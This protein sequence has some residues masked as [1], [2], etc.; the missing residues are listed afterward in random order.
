METQ[1]S[2]LIKQIQL[3]TK[4]QTIGGIPRSIS[5]QIV[6]VVE[7]NP[8]LTKASFAVNGGKTSSGPTTIITTPTNQ[9]FYLTSVIFS[10]TKDAAC[11]VAS[12]GINLSCVINGATVNFC[13]IAGLTLTAQSATVSANYGMH[14]IKIDRGTNILIANNTYAAGN[15][16]RTATITYF[17]DECSNA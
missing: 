11:D 17:V 16:I 7:A 1:S 13:P 4:I 3:A 10:M 2:E 6:P 14:P 5:N 12:G 9:D 15:M 8:M